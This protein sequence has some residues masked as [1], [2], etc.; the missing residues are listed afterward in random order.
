[1]NH[2]FSN[3][4][5]LRTIAQ[6]ISSNFEIQYNTAYYTLNLMFSQA[7]IW[8]GIYF[9]PFIVLMQTLKLFFMFFIKAVSWLKLLFFLL[10]WKI[11]FQ[12]AWFYNKYVVKR[13]YKMP[14]KVEPTAKNNAYL[15]SLTFVL[16]ML[17]VISMSIVNSK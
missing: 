17:I 14:K 3:K 15:I 12:L 4:Q 8:I 1:M 11:L 7:L 2:N 10:I 16:N 13:L 5:N 9:S 6:R